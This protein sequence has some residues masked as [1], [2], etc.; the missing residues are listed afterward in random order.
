MHFEPQLGSKHFNTTGF[1]SEQFGRRLLQ[2]RIVTEPHIEIAVA[3][4]G[5]R[6]GAAHHVQRSDRKTRGRTSVVFERTDHA[7]GG[8]YD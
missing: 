4:V 6:T 2:C 7:F 5:N 1:F 8:A 3:G